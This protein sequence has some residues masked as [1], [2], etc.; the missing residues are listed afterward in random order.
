M[1][2]ISL[3]DTFKKVLKTVSINDKYNIKC[4]FENIYQNRFLKTILSF[5]R[6]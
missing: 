4:Y 6:S 3:K 2:M 1:Y 5:E